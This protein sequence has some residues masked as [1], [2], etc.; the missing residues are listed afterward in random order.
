MG[1][2]VGTVRA[3]I[4]ILASPFVVKIKLPPP[5]TS[6][7]ISERDKRGRIIHSQPP[8]LVVSE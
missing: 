5:R 3:Q 8:Q 1:L 4:D 7:T 2:T 6:R